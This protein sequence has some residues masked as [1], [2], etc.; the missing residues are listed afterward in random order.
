MAPHEVCV[1]VQDASA[2]TQTLYPVKSDPCKTNRVG[3]PVTTLRQTTHVPEGGTCN[4]PLRI[5]QR[6]ALA[7]AV[8]NEALLAMVVAR[9]ESSR[10]NSNTFF[11][12]KRVYLKV[13]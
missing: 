8:R 3:G 7:A 13:K 12:L 9:V 6:A 2:E 1:D 4:P 11:G 5:I 10:T